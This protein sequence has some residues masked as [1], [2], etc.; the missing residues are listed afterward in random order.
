MNTAALTYFLETCRCGSFS[1]AAE[2]LYLSP[3][4]IS[5]AVRTLEEELGCP[6]FLRTPGGVRLTEQGVLVRTYAQ[7]IMEEVNQMQEELNRISGTPVHRG[8]LG[9][10]MGASEVLGREKLFQIQRMASQ[11]GMS[12]VDSVDLLCEE[13]VLSGTYDLAITAGPVDRNK[14][15]AKT[16]YKGNLCAFV[17]KSHPFYR[18]EFITYSDL[19]GQR[20]IT[21]NSKFRTYHQLVD[22]CRHYGFEPKIIATTITLR[23]TCRSYPDKTVIGVSTYLILGKIN[24]QD[25][26]AV[27][28]VD[29]NY[30]W[31]LVLIAKKAKRLSDAQTGLYKRIL[32]CIHP[33]GPAALL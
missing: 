31:E 7:R 13:E 8:C 4:G 17:H 28:I 1:E 10:T 11:A 30:C 23:D 6:L 5:K 9:I 22:A 20:I 18:R 12:W 26:R 15:S 3:Q 32:T 29:E 27:P 25:F 24:Y 16:L 21:T 2:R 19:K 14:F 33:E